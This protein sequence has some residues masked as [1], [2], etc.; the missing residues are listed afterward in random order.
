MR[1]PYLSQL[2]LY[3]MKKFFISLFLL[4]LLVVTPVCALDLGTKEGSLLDGAGKKA[5]YDVSGTTKTTL[6]SNIGLIINMALSVMGVIFTVLMVYA[7]YLWM[8]AQG[9]DDQI[10]KAKK[11][12]TTAIVGMIITL[13]AFSITTFI[14]PRILAATLAS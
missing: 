6:S 8:T 12:I 1:S 3:N 10:D 4:S 11:M 13:G 14:I 7:G 9:K 2:I 5:G